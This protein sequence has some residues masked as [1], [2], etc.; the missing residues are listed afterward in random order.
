MGGLGLD[1]FMT[2]GDPSSGRKFLKDWKKA[3]EIIVWLSTRA[4]LAYPSYN[5]PFMT[6]G[7]REKKDREGNKTGKDEDYLQFMRFV[8]PDPAI[9][10]D[11]QYFRE[12]SDDRLQV[13]PA[14]D[15]F[16][17]LR[18]WLRFEADHL[19]L[20]TVIFEWKNP[21]AGPKQ[22]AVIQWNRGEL[23][24]M[25]KRGQANF[26]HSLD[27][28]LDYYF[29]VA[30]DSDPAAGPQIVRGTKLLGDKMRE[31]IKAQCKSNGREG[32]DPQQNPYA[33]CWNYDPDAGSPM[34]Y[35]KASR[36]NQAKL[37][38]AVRKA[39]ME[40]DFPDPTPDTKPRAGD[41]AKL[42][43][44]MTDAARVELPFDRFFVDAWKDEAPEGGSGTDF[45]FGSN[46]EKPAAEETKTPPRAAATTPTSGPKARR[47]KKK[48]EPAPE[49]EV[50]M[51]PCED[52]NTP[53]PVTCEK[54]PKCGA[55]Y[56]VGDDGADDAQ[57]AQAAASPQTSV[58]TKCW[59][60][61]ST[62][63][64]DD[65]CGGCGLDI[66]DDIP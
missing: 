63:I 15:P 51:I 30:D 31:E 42:L 64:Q 1:G 32:G 24:R 45:D 48:A 37:T 25:V 46:K 7:T 20:D 62:D 27:T 40:A 35:Y 58:G 14:A 39:I 8:S 16:L 56:E 2:F 66:T 52:C 44:A 28:K 12:Q 3:R 53:L 61:G 57:P 65:R 54:C 9:V 41:K 29:V 18:E 34:N 10:H 23:A 50:E 6:L 47:R 21:N 26:G 49:P 33:F 19:S 38:E 4:D 43:A 59:S 5:H 36:Y 17:L 55:E 60:C 13:A 11:N 22:E